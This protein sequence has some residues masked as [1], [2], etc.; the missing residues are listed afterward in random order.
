MIHTYKEAIGWIHSRLKF[1][2]KPGLERMRWMLEELGNPERHIKCVHLAGT[3]G[4]GSTLTYMRYMLEGA[5]YKV[6][7]FTSPYI[8]SFNERISVNGTPIADEEITELVKLVKPVVEKLDETDLGEATEFEIITVMAI[9]Y[10]GKFNFCDVVLFETGLGGRFDSTNVIHPV[11]TIITNIGHDHMH[12]LGNTLGEIAYEKAGIIKSGVPVITGVQDEE[13]LQ[14]IQNVAKENHANL[15]EMGNHFTALHKQSSEDGEQFDFTCPFASFEDVRIT[16]KGSHQVGNAALALMAVMYVK[17][18]VSFL[19][20][21]EEIRT[22]LQ[23]AYWVGRFEKLQSNPDIIIDGAHNP[24][25]IESLVKTVEA[26]YKD[27]NVIVL[28]TALGDKQ[29]HNMVGQ[30]ETIADEIIFTTFAFDRAISA[31]KLASY[32]Q[33]ESKLVFENWKEA[34]DT[35][36][37][38]IA[39][40][41][42][43]IITGSLYFISEVRKY[44]CEKN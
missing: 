43:F 27:K 28:F 38:M 44:I 2:M 15:Y 11:L 23:E 5:K 18:Y 4:K 30:L 32:S 7:T 1:G 10:F 13:A 16:M 26:H 3:N 37:E 20:E 40:N 6:G 24:E 36:V 33:K 41:D 31:D 22:G 25:G 9:C 12:I 8:E 35:K 14:V 21:E 34:I 19:I 17:T 42:V 29:L 39:E